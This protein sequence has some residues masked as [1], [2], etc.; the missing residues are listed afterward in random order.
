MRETRTAR[1]SPFDAYT[2]DKSLR[3]FLQKLSC[4]LYEHPE[5]LP[6]IAENFQYKT[7]KATDHKGLSI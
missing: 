3:G 7:L 1:S 6:L 4:L 5:I 2:R